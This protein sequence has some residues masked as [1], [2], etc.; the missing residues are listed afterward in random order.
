MLDPL[1]GELLPPGFNAMPL[2]DRTHCA[3]VDAEVLRQ[4]AHLCARLVATHQ[5]GLLFKRQS[6]LRLLDDPADRGHRTTYSEGNSSLVASVE[7]Q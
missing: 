2:E 5:F 7:A 6:S 1:A 3:A 4:V